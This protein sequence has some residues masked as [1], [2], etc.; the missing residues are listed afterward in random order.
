MAKKQDHILEID[1]HALRF[2]GKVI[3]LRSIAYFEKVRTRR[4]GGVL[5]RLFI[6]VLIVA[7]IFAGVA[8]SGAGASV[9]VLGVLAVLVLWNIVG[10]FFR[11]E[12]FA[13]VV[14]TT[15]GD[16]PELFSTQD[17]VFLDELVGELSRRM[18]ESADLPPLVAN[19][20]NATITQGDHVVGDKIGGD[21]VGGDKISDNVNSTIVNRST[22]TNAMNRAETR[23]DAETAAALEKVAELIE[24]QGD[25][26]AAEIFDRF[27]EELSKEAPSKTMLRTFWDGLEKALPVLAGMTDITVKV[28]KLFV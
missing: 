14:Q 16:N 21:K 20:E 17:G 4:R 13:L 26:V 28:A 19:I 3:P 12:A 11:K 18:Q 9:L 22:L 25:A 6:S 24:A 23:A 10:L 7:A 27:N 8:L 1:N 15:A 5:R 2:A